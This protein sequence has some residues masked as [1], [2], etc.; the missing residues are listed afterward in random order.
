MYDWNLN[1]KADFRDKVNVIVVKITR[2]DKRT[3]KRK[4]AEGIGFHAV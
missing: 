1:D 3:R 4:I 2:E